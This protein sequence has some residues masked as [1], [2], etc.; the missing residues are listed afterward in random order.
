MNRNMDELGRLAFYASTPHEC[1]Y[2]PGRSAQTLFADPRAHMT[3]RLYSRLAEYGFRRSGGMIYRPACPGCAAC[4]PVRI[5]VADFR[6]RRSQR[7]NLQRNRDLRVRA[8]PAGFDAQQYALYR[9]YIGERHPGGGMDE[10]DEERYLEFLTS[11]WA[12]TTFH[13][14]RAGDRLLSVAVVDRMETGLS[15]VYTF[16]DPDEGRRGPGVFAV[17][18]LIGEA[19]RLGLPYLYL[20]Y[21][22]GDCRKMAY[23]SQYRPLEGLRDGEWRRIF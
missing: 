13:E 5:P 8:T 6:P 22:I 10:A 3:T 17:L 1:D 18:W 21:W 14:F 9:R 2:L 23:K 19:R 4:V 12:A 16:F 15:A 7:R 20:G 11:P